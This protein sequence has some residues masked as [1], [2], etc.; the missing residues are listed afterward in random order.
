MLTKSLE[1]YLKELSTERRC[2]PNTIEAYRRDLAPWV[3]FLLG[4][5][6]KLP[7]AEKNDP[8]FLRLYLRQRSEQ[9][10]SNRSLA[11]FLAAVSSFQKFLASKQGARQYIFKL[12]RMKYQTKIPDFIPQ[13]E[14]DRLFK[15]ANTR[16]D[17][18]TYFYW[19]DFIMIAL[20]YATG[21]RREELANTKLSDMELDR[22]VMTVT[23]K[24][25][26]IR[27]VPI[28]EST[29]E[30]LRR[31]LP[32][33][34]EFQQVKATDS[35]FLLLNRDGYRLSV[36]SID[37]LAR[38]FAVKAGMDFTPHTL[39]HS[40]ATHLL[41]NGADL[42]LI[43]EILGHSSLSTTQKYTHVTAESMKKAYRTAHPR[44]GLKE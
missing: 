40:F 42:I 30:D 8:L 31:Y 33:R 43:K 18:K 5:Y 10:I 12:P 32:M 3:E 14:A 27:V 17:K 35:P 39:R 41:E 23:G 25:N 29:L 15:H 37:R 26:K 9:K 36:R 13:S 21:I 20:M 34:Q 16:S 4:Q 44:S 28:G 2:S 22:G 1:K 7:H 11:R 24:G 6:Q 38:A 19:R